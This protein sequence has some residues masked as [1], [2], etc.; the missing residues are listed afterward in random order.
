MDVYT[1][2]CYLG[3][4]YYCC[5]YLRKICVGSITLKN[6]WELLKWK[7]LHILSNRLS[8]HT[9]LSRAELRSESCCPGPALKN[10]SWRRFP[11]PS[12]VAESTPSGFCFILLS[13]T[14]ICLR[15]WSLSPDPDPVT[16]PAPPP[17]LPS[18]Q[19]G[20][21]VGRLGWNLTCFP[22]P[23]LDA[24]RCPQGD[25]HLP[26]PR[27]DSPST[28]GHSFRSLAAPLGESPQVRP[29]SL[30]TRPPALPPPMGRDYSTPPS[31]PA[32]LLSTWRP[33]LP[34]PWQSCCP[35]LC[36]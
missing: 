34:D 24:P 9:H 13:R 21:E 6:K 25:W 19:L 11:S 18:S 29:A 3:N 20:P 23:S 36:L 5:I 27:A 17:G 31:F 30:P 33:D 32:Q 1:Y 2:I 8:P 10:S 14:P 15:S 16:G 22:L 28:L 4:F 7:Y 35:L 26:K 12:Q